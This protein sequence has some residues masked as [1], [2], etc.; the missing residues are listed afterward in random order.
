MAW[1]EWKDTDV[2]FV[3]WFFALSCNTKTWRY[4][5]RPARGM[6]RASTQSASSYS[7]QINCGNPCVHSIVDIWRGSAGEIREG[8]WKRDFWR[9]WS[10]HNFYMAR[11]LWA[12]SGWQLGDKFPV[13]FFPER[14]TSGNS[15]RTDGYVVLWSGQY[16]CFSRT[17]LP[18]V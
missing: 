12:A 13:I 2:G 16:Y 6:L 9:L 8:S 4:E 10:S 1:V 17:V 11:V 18:F 3:V 15:R 5:I 7:L 14:S